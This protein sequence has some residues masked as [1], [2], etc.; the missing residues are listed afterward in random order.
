MNAPLRTLLFQLSLLVLLSVALPAR[1]SAQ[2]VD[3]GATDVA[4]AVG[5]PAEVAARGDEPDAPAPAAAAAAARRPAPW[6][7]D[8]PPPD[9]DDAGADEGDSDAGALARGPKV[10][11]VTGAGARAAEPRA[12]PPCPACPAAAPGPTAGPTPTPAPRAAA[13]AAPS[14]GRCLAARLAPLLSG[15]ALAGADVGAVVARLED[16]AV[17]FDRGAATTL[18]PASTSKLLTAA[19]ALHHLGPSWR[20]ET[21]VWSDA[22]RGG[23]IEGDVFVQG[24]GDPTIVAATLLEW[25]EG[26]R[27]RGVTHVKGGVVADGGAFPGPALAP[28][29]DRKPTDDS[30]RPAVA[31]FAYQRA[32][33][34]AAI[35]PGDAVG[36][37][38]RVDLGLDADYFVLEN[39]CKTVGGAEGQPTIETAAAGRRTKVIVGGTMGSAAGRVLSFRRVEDPLLQ[40][41]YAFHGALRRVGIRVD[42]EPRTGALPGGKR[43]RIVHPSP[44]L[45]AVL[46]EMN[47]ESDNFYAEMVF[48]TVGGRSA[49][50]G[51]TWAAG[52]RAVATWLA[53]LRRADDAGPLFAAAV[54]SPDAW[55]FENGSGLYDV[56]RL[57]P[58]LL[59][60]ALRDAALA[61]A[62]GAEFLASLPIAG[63]DGTLAHR[64]RKSA[65]VDRARGKTGSL[66]GIDALAGVVTAKDG[67]TY[68]YAFLVNRAKKPHADVR[69]A[70]D[71]A[72]GA[73]AEGCR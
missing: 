48:R 36:A 57:S 41:A 46:Q 30:Y 69:A 38:C 61:P 37:A 12:C 19:A 72:L 51:A 7:H 56:N 43:P 40:A 4:P 47:K 71:R 55:D 18:I 63:R 62:S 42:R 16:G 15:P 58:A 50:G 70:L 35:Y 44:P 24:A 28:G 10:D 52:A 21:K 60:R 23:V 13:A 6:H 45:A 65:A 20:W 2:P 39:R 14:A 8:A 33:L 64:A 17:V 22:Q 32:A 49:K 54:L 11:A 1:P 59:A 26:L 29:F 27:E 67:T 25:A 3:A 53:G 5:A 31:A 34:R 9:E 66:D 73:V 68:V